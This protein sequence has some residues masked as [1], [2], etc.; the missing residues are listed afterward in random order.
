FFAYGISTEGEFS[1]NGSGSFVS[2][3]IHANEGF[4]LNGSQEFRA[5]THRNASG[6]CTH[7]E[8]VGGGFV[9]ISG[10]PGA[11]CS[12]NPSQPAICQN[13][14]PVHLTDPVTITPNYEERRDAAMAAVSHGANTSSFFGIDCDLRY[15]SR[16]N[17]VT[18]IL[19]AIASLPA[20][21]T[22]CL[23]Y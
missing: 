19:S 10:S 17:P 12:V 23:E 11:S 4:S 21:S 8:A 2:A 5:C 18:S 1:G 13:K 20:G 16:P 3:G 6:V 15:T 9:P 22:V 7:T 14:K